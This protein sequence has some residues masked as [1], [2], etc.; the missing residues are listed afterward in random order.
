M[1]N[2]VTINAPDYTIDGDL[3]IL[4]TT[5]HSG[6]WQSPLFDNATIVSGNSNPLIIGD[7][8]PNEQEIYIV[9]KWQTKAPIIIDADLIISLKKD[10]LSE[11]ELYKKIMDKI[12][13]D[14]P[15]VALKIG[16]N[17]LRIRKLSIPI[18]I[19]DN[20]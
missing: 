7:K 16:A 11:D 12:N 14:Y 15:E 8:D 17:K 18:E 20:Q 3:N 4:S 13:S 9:E 19:K 2:T 10:I 5:L 6:S 1:D